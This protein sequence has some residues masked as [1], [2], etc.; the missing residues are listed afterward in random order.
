[1]AP[2]E[3]YR[4][5]LV[6]PG[7]HSDACQAKAVE[8]LQALYEA[9]LEPPARRNFWQRL[10]GKQLPP[11]RGLYLWGGPGRGKTWLV[12]AF[13]GSL[14]FN[15]KRRVHFH[16]FM[17]EIHE[18]LDALPKTPDPL[19]I[20]ADQL[21][22][23]VRLLCIDEFHVTDVADAMLLA[24]LLEAL[25]ERQVTLV[26]TSNIEP[27]RLYH[28][29]LQRA[30]FV[31]AI[32]LIEQ[33]T[34][35]LVLDGSEDYRLALLQQGGTSLVG[36][37]LEQARRWLRE[38]LDA[39]A[40]VSPTENGVLSLAGRELHTVALA[41]GI[42]WFT[43]DE[44]CLR[45]RSAR[46]YLEL[47]CEFHTLLLETVPVMSA[48]MDEGARRFMHL[49]DALYDHG[50][51]LVMTVDATPGQLYTGQQLVQPF[52]RTASRLT[53]MA[54]ESYLSRPHQPG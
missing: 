41:D 23:H 18:A 5:A 14:P 52:Q 3:H 39:L 22:E 26:A 25:F 11:V 19:L 54:S 7:F 20:V 37:D 51:K 30:R 29:G 50:V 35:V 33:H 44:L 27:R 40:G 45:P 17:L 53:E 31:P 42:A 13:F 38:H 48:E 8:Y 4:A 43:F 24:G 36:R 21:A 12:D 6:T 34:E 32:E 47:G 9:L 15:K 49:I 2:R 28:E 1:M 10:S 46:D 16:R